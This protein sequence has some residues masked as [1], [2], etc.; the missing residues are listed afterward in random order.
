MFGESPL[1]DCMDKVDRAFAVGLGAWVGGVIISWS[2][3]LCDSILHQEIIMEWSELDWYG[4]PT[5]CV[6]RKTFG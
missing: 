3:I 5:N 1:V 2:L 6:W 4:A